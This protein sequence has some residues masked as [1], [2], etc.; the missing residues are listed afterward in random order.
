MGPA[1]PI[2]PMGPAGSGGSGPIF[3]IS[4]V[5]PTMARWWTGTGSFY[6]FYT[7]TSSG[8]E[9][10]RGAPIPVAC[11]LSAITMY[12][13][14]N[15]RSLGDGPDTLTLTIFKNNSATLMT[16]SATS[17]TTVH[18]AISSSCSSNP[19]S[20]AAGDTLGLQ[21]THTNTSST[22]FTQYGAG[23]QCQ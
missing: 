6:S 10:S 15:R 12:A 13:S 17:T 1:G 8:E 20:L 2:G 16:C 14:T 22:L 7:N 5:A 3:L 23:L 11:N 9:P 18:E 19:V 4:G 21:W